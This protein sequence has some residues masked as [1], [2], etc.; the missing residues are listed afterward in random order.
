YTAQPQPWIHDFFAVQPALTTTAFLGNLT[1]LQ[2]I[3][4]TPSLGSNSPLWSLTYEL[5]YYL[6]FPAASLALSTRR[7]MRDKMGYGAVAVFLGFVFGWAVVLYFPIWLFGLA[8]RLAPRLNPISRTPPFLRNG[9]A[10]L[11]VLLGLTFR[12]TSQFQNLTGESIAIGDYMIVAVFAVAL[13]ILLHDSRP[14]RD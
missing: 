6:I 7:R 11:I 13:F 2:R 8:V 14:A 12:H 3:L 5:A 9:G 1:F 10:A 4:M